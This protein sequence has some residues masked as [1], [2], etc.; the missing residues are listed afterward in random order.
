MKEWFISPTGN[1][2]N[3]GSKDQPFAALAAAVKASRDVK[4]PKRIVLQQGQ[5]YLE[6]AIELDIRD[7]GL[8]IESERGAKAVLFGGRKIED[9]Q[10]D[11]DKFYSASVENVEDRTWDFRSLLV[12][13]RFCDRARLPEA[14]R[15]EH[16]TRFDVGWATTLERPCHPGF[17][18]EPT[19][20]E[21]TTLIFNEGNIDSDTDIKNAE[22]TIF[23]CWETSLVGVESIDWET[24]TVKFCNRSGMPPGAFGTHQFAINNT[25][26]GM[27]KPG[28]WYLD[29]TNS[30][31]VYWPL[32][33]EDMSKAHV[34]APSIESI[35]RIVGDKDEPVK[36]IT[37]K[38]LTLSMTTTTLEGVK[39][40]YGEIVNYDGG[41]RTAR[42]E[43]ALFAAYIKNCN[44]I[45]LEVA[46][47]GGQ[48]IK[49][50]AVDNSKIVNCHIHHS[51]S[52]AVTLFGN[53]TVFDNCHVHDVGLIYP[54]VEAVAVRGM[55]GDGITVSNCDIHDVSY[56][57]IHV[58]T[59][60]NHVVENNLVYNA[61]KEMRDGSGIYLSFCHH[62][63]VKGNF[64]R[65][66][67]MD[68][69]NK[70][71]RKKGEYA[72]TQAH[73]Y[74]LDEQSENCL[75]EGNLALNCPSPYQGHQARNNVFRNNFFINEKDDIL[76]HMPLSW[77]EDVTQ[78]VIYSGQGAILI[79]NRKA[80]TSFKNNL[81]Y[82]GSG[83]VEAYDLDFYS[84]IEKVT[85]DMT[86]GSVVADPLFV[87]FKDGKIMLKPDSP[88]A[89]LGIKPIDV[90]KAGVKKS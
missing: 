78:N 25:R 45:D 1:D 11:G 19:W 79:G 14:G 34:V 87:S 39:E 16:D 13:D 28:Q 53:G 27:T 15:Y 61:M 50:F 8:S 55:F 51:G 22:L 69:I 35:I 4:A 71:N 62:V 42:V 68:P 47:A 36:D 32:P 85:L 5:Y 52:R 72:H 24:N 30:R 73:A 29:R 46:N 77:C 43:G 26:E 21:V 67:E 80:I 23:N 88:V 9:W 65:D 86:T 54:A 70:A 33:D 18:R 84:P 49:M 74:Y 83:K 48:G 12:N 76:W 20:D 59:A 3:S 60:H 38:G 7:E 10:P 31:I 41:D 57:A 63:T 56:T 81:L 58:I 2:G 89:A 40:T 6:N 37:I 82:S 17:W 64:V 75:I 90:G 66:V 44:F